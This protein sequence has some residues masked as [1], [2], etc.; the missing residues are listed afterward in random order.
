MHINDVWKTRE[1]GVRQGANRN[2]VEHLVRIRNAA[3]R[4]LSSGF[5]LRTNE[6]GHYAIMLNP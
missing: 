3:W 2:E 5:R 4:R 1:I 6:T